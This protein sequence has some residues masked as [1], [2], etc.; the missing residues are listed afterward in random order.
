MKCKWWTR[1]N[2]ETQ[3]G[4]DVEFTI[5]FHN[6]PSGNVWHKSEV[7]AECAAREVKAADCKTGYATLVKIVTE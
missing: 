6:R 1:D 2:G 7:C 3:C 4:N 5:L